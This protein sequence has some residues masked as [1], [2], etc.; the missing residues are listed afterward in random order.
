MR[1][2]SAPDPSMAT[3]FNI[4]SRMGTEAVGRVPDIDLIRLSAQFGFALR[5]IIRQ[6][7]LSV[8]EIIDLL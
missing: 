6:A 4:E 1:C 2:S 8:E 5:S 3:R 7:G